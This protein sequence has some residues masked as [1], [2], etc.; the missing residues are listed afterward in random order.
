[1]QNSLDLQA[2][3]NFRSVKA[4]IPWQEF[5]PPFLFMVFTFVEKLVLKHKR[6]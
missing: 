3:S 5:V 1:L 4:R 2:P 6:R